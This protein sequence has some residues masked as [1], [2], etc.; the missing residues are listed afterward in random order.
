[1]NFQK[2]KV[3]ICTFNHHL[4][5]LGKIL[6]DPPKNTPKWGEKPG[7]ILLAKI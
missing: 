1:M 3:I 2:F 6:F 4:P 7:K 5:L